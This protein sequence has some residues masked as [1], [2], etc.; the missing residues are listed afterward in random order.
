M[1]KHYARGRKA[2][3]FSDRSGFRYDL[4]DM[5]T[6]WN[7]LKVGFDEY[8]PK[9]P[10]LEPVKH[11]GDAIALHDP[12]PDTRVEE[13][14]P[15]S[16]LLFLNPFRSAAQ[17]SNTITVTERSHGRSSGDIVRFRKVIGFDG[18]SHVVIEQA[19]GYSI[20]VVDENSYLFTA[21]SGTAVQGNRVGGGAAA[22]V[23][24]VTLEP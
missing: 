21:A 14:I 2:F 16:R 22:T 23:G 19:A 8:E 4:D 3:G 9:H 20:T 7:G 18:F 12:R 17:G 15:P 1:S 5:V 10:Q 24:P 6:E 11:S 13:D